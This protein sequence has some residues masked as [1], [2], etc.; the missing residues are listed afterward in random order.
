VHR[1][2]LSESRAQSSIGWRRSKSGTAR[3]G[4]SLIISTGTHPE[5]DRFLSL[6]A[7]VA[8]PSPPSFEMNHR[9]SQRQAQ[10]HYTQTPAPAYNAGYGGYGNHPPPA[11]GGG[12]YPGYAAPPPPQRGPPHGADPELWNAF[13]SVDTDRSGSITVT[14]LQSALVNGAFDLPFGRSIRRSSACAYTKLIFSFVQEIGR[15][16]G[17]P[18]L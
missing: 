1:Q 17:N 7:H 13:S 18:R 5:L 10:P 14:E 4:A 12:G 9:H 16:S 3:I 15:V 2:G 11:Q 8:W 6:P